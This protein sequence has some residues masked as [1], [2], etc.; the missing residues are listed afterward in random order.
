VFQSLRDRVAGHV[1]GS[2]VLAAAR[3]Q[4][5]AGLRAATAMMVP[6]VV[7]WT[8]DRPVLIWAS[9][10]GWLAM[11]T[12]PGGPYEA[13]AGA[14]AVFAAA[15]AFNTFAGCLVGHSPWVAVP[16]LF[17]FALVCSLVRVR[18]DT[19]AVIG[20]L[21]LIQFCIAQGSPA[22][23]H[24]SLWRAAL[25]AAGAMFALLLSV[26]VWPFRP[27]E[28]VRE[29]VA[30]C[31]SAIAD[32]A[33]A[34]SRLSSPGTPPAA[35]DDL[36]PLR[37]GAREALEEA[38]AALGV[39][40]A[41]R[42]GESARGLH[43]LVLYEVA[44]LL[45][46]DLAALLEALR[47]RIERGQ[48]LPPGI[49]GA[50]G[51]LERT[52]EAVA[53]AVA[54]EAPLPDRPSLSEE[55]PDGEL[56]ALFS[57]VTAET[58]QAWESAHA[59]QHGGAASH[60]PGLLPARDE[61]PSLRDALAP[62]SLELQHSLRVAIVAT[63]AAL[64]AAALQIRRSYWVTITVVIILQPHSIATV[65]RALQRVGG[66]VIGGVV[67][68]LM[69]RAVHQRFWLG[70]LLFA[71]AFV[72]VAIRRINYALFA[73]LVTPVFVILAE[74]NARGAH[75]IQERILDTLLGGT[76]ALAGALLLW[77][78]RDLD[79]LPSLI[80]AVLRADRAYLESI[81]RGESPATA[82][83]ARRRVGLETANAEAALQRLIGE[84]PPAGEVESWM[85]S[86]AYARRL[87]AS[88]TG[89][90]TARVSREQ[91]QRLIEALASLAT[92]AESRQ[93]PPELADIEDPRMPEAAL[94]LARQL[95]VVQSAL[96]RLD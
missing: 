33:G 52:Q 38:R 65:R 6:L 83:A 4:W 25:F 87:S 45:L 82:A 61:W 30:Q 51:D 76:L 68:S 26:A 72:G 60:H 78:H 77:P 74:M 22:S 32:L 7:G 14:M 88:I 27:Y 41:G 13:R 17:L 1:R 91:G 66:T 18:G 36:V 56:A 93:P 53:R 28:P 64:V 95:R 86:I 48:P 39:A 71:F 55:P 90:A 92:A 63:V 81:L 10:G 50:L 20:V 34:V 12:D 3:P 19:A 35:W 54:E 44:E 40:R 67:A 80:G 21:A 16:A 15:G 31:W 62:Q 2:L 42:L 5:S 70:P 46:G 23:L 84:A 37:R 9:L 43:L 59:L 58:R 73:A 79:R 8:T 89:L 69:A 24:E 94:R 85:A 96:A 49:A 57:R 11:L 75:L 47:S 29:A